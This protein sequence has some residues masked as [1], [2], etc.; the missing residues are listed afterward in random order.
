MNFFKKTPKKNNICEIQ[1]CT[2]ELLSGQ[3]VYCTLHVCFEKGC[4]DKRRKSKGPNVQPYCNEHSCDHENCPLPANKIGY[5]GKHCINHKCH[6]KG[7]FRDNETVG[8]HCLFHTCKHKDCNRQPIEGHDFCE[9]HGCIVC[10]EPLDE[11][12]NEQK[13]T[14]CALGLKPVSPKTLIVAIKASE[15]DRDDDTT[16][17]SSE[18]D[19]I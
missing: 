5:E 17:S 15:F 10:N 2:N 4:Q 11:L 14:R 6:I 19:I 1:E 12:D 18:D 3:V 7:C 13:C 16:T 9:Y 8:F